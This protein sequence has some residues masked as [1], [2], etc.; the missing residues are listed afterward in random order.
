MSRSKP[1][2]PSAPAGRRAWSLGLPSATGLVVGSVI[3]TGVFT[4]PAVLAGAG[5]SSLVVLS[6]IA[7]GAALLAVLFGQLT[8]RVPDADGGL[9]AYA[10]NEFGDFAGYLTGWCYWV[11]AWVGNAAIVS[12]WVLYVD[13]L[14][15]IDNPAGW[16]N[17]GIAL[18]GLWVPALVNLSGVRQIAWF[19]NLTVAVKFLPLLLVAVVGWFF[20]SNA[21]FGAFN[22]SGGSLYSAIGITAGVA[23]FA[24]IGV[25]VAAVTAK[26]VRDPG[27]NVGRASLLGTAASAI[28]YV[29]VSAAVMGLVPHDVL[30]NTGTPFVPAVEAI[31]PH[32]AWAGKLVAALAVVSGIGALNGWTLVTA[33][34]SRAAAND[35][36][37]PRFFTWADRKD[38]AWLGVLVAAALPS[39]LMLWRYTATSGLAVFTFLVNLSV[40]TIAVP[41]LFSAC[42]QL[43]YLVSRRRRVRGWLLVRDLL[44]TGVSVLFSLWVT[45]AAGY[46]AV[47]QAMFLMLLGL[48]LY[49]FVKARRERRHEAGDGATG[50]GEQWPRAA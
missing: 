12:S 22:A 11:S 38:T 42:A 5:T 23:L 20:V 46:A 40:V 41:Y 7:A 30:V 21:N 36:L 37:F 29:A 26:R 16:T 19:E 28:L 31:F 18:L 17:W 39:L 25:E 48:V 14:L 3:G 45:F 49:A 10:R 32:A 15:G 47:Y 43:S 27:R 6:V 4:M 8:R 1:A 24:F 34:V 50:P 35:G 2:R 13:S 44:V 9:Y 33:E